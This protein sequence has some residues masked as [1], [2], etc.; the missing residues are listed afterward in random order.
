MNFADNNG[1]FWHILIGATVGAVISGGTK[2]LANIAEGKE[3]NDGLGIAAVSGALSGAL[4][5]TGVGIGVMVA[6]N[7]AISMA[8]NAA[9]QL[10]DLSDG[11]RS[12]FDAEE[13]L[14]E[15][16]IGGAFALAGGAPSGSKYMTNLGKQT[17]RRTANSLKY[18]GIQAAL[19]EAQKASAYYLKNTKNYYKEFVRGIRRDCYLSLAKTTLDLLR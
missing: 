4:A 13:M 12:V 16:V 8:E 7:V 6:G 2:I 15:G 10:E 18:K 9:E 1:Q 3:W 14:T 19:L 5:A 17:V 11:S